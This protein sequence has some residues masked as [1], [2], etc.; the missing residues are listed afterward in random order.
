MDAQSVRGNHY[1]V[2]GQVEH[3]DI[4]G[5]LGLDYF[6]GCATKYLCRWRKKNGIEDLYKALSFLEKAS[7]YALPCSPYPKGCERDLWVLEAL[8]G[9]ALPMAERLLAAAIFRGEPLAECIEDLKVIIK[10]QEEHQ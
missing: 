8:N 6:R 7:D 1:K 2:A 4:V 10:Y 3:W 5:H 9:Y